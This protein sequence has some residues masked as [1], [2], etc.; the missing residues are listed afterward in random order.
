MRLT[1][2]H[3]AFASLIYLRSPPAGGSF[4]AKTGGNGKINIIKSL[5]VLKP[6]VCFVIICKLLHTCIRVW[7]K[8]T[9]RVVA[10]MKYRINNYSSFFILKTTKYGK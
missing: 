4:L 10:G 5:V 7:A 9:F 1:G 6:W 8:Q 2:H 3:K